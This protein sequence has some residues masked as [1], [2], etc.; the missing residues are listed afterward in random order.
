MGVATARCTGSLFQTPYF[1]P[2]GQVAPCS[3]AVPCEEENMATWGGCS[4][5]G[6]GLVVCPYDPAH[7]VREDR[8]CIHVS[9]CH[10]G[11]RRAVVTCRYNGGHLVPADRIHEHLATCPDRCSTHPRQRVFYSRQ[12]L[13]ADEADELYPI[14]PV[15]ELPEPEESWDAELE[16]GSQPTVPAE[17]Y[18]KRAP[19]G[20]KSAGPQQ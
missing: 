13:A 9:R 15:E 12:A 7:R 17:P 10:R 20:S 14:K 11:R 18:F 3:V 4:S 8:L 19:P 5:S 1:L 2:L 6:D 16:E